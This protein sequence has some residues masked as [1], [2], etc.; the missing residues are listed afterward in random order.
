MKRLI[1]A[2]IVIAILLPVYESRADD[3]SGHNK[4]GNGDDEYGDG[5]VS[6][7]TG[8]SAEPGGYDVYSDGSNIGR[9]R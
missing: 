1:V 5:D 7:D 9:R 3:K 2:L 4:I 8:T 6:E